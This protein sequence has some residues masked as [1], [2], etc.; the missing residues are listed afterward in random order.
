MWFFMSF[1]FG[2]SRVNL[3]F[4]QKGI[5]GKATRYVELDRFFE[6]SS[7][8]KI[9]HHCNAAWRPRKERKAKL[10]LQIT[11]LIE[12]QN[13]ADRAS[14]TLDVFCNAPALAIK[15]QMFR[16]SKRTQ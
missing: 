9:Q 15:M 6:P 2:V 16:N 13:F 7:S 10:E 11:Y 1:T 12:S 3:A 8:Y 4:F 14:T 5:L